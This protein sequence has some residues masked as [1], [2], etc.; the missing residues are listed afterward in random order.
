MVLSFNNRPIP[1][2]LFHHCR[3]F[4]SKITRNGLVRRQLPVEAV[5]F[6]I[7]KMTWPIEPATPRGERRRE[8]FLAVG[9][10][11]KNEGRRVQSDTETVYGVG[12]CAV[13]DRR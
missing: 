7:L 3:P 6:K 13:V 2:V 12:S 5:R 9:N 11:S 1:T 8:V 10:Y 4:S